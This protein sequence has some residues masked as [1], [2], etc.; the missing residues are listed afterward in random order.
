MCES[1]FFKVC[2]E[3]F[4]FIPNH[5]IE[6][7]S[8]LEKKKMYNWKNQRNSLILKKINIIFFFQQQQQNECLDI[9]KQ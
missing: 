1:D 9:E 3:L 6:I 7:G 4:M 8:T 2:I 5:Y